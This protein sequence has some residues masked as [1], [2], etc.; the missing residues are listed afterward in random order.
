MKK[1]EMDE[2]DTVY[3]CGL[4]H[5]RKLKRIFRLLGL[6]ESGKASR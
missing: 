6:S 5:S 4:A 1:G 3:K 2:S